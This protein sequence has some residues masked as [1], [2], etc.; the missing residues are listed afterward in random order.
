MGWQMVASFNPTGGRPMVFNS[1]LQG[2]SESFA[3]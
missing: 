3:G 2:V 1:F